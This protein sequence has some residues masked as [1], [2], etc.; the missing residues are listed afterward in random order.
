LFVEIAL[1]IG[2]PRHERCNV[3][4]VGVRLRFV[5]AARACC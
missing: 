4:R 5:E 3:L 2:L 1:E